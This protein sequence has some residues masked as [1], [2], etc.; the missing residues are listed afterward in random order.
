MTDAPWLD[1]MDGFKYS[2]EPYPDAMFEEAERKE[3]IR[4]LDK[5]CPQSIT[6]PTHICR[7]D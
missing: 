3:D 1:C 5:V 6:N 4:I 2:Q 7:R